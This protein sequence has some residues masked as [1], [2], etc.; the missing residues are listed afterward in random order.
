MIRGLIAYIGLFIL[1][2]AISIG[3]SYFGETFTVLWWVI[4]IPTALLF[5]RIVSWR[6]KE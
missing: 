5:L 2:V 6:V 4:F 3:L 1:G